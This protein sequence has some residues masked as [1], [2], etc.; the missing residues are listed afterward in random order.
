MQPP[1][2]AVPAPTG[3]DAWPWYFGLLALVAGLF[4]AFFVIAVL[5]GIWAAGGGDINGPTF[6][7]IAT[8][9]QAVVFVVTVFAIA[10]S[11]GPVSFRDFGLVRAPFWPTVGKMVA[12]ILS[13]FVLL[14]IWNALVHLA[15]DNAPDKLGAN[16]GTLGMLGFAVLVAVLAP[17]SEEIFFRGMVFRA[18]ANG[19]GVWAGAFFSGLL[20]GSLHIDSLSHDRLLQVVPLA[21]LGMMFALLYAWSGTIYSTIA[22]HATNNSLAVLIYANDHDSSFGVVL[23]IVLWV[24]MMLGCALGWRLT[25]NGADAPAAPQPPAPPA[26]YPPPGPE[27]PD[28]PWGQP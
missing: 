2:S 1:P 18:F 15:P 5:S 3:A 20:F 27:N 11:R 12:T 25:D 22:L 16:T 10:R 6:T 17:I 7:V 8:A 24:L 4:G 14:A 13:Y 28:F 9:A 21:L 26:R 23:A 19:A